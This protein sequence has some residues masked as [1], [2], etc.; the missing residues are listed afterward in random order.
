ML[1]AGSCRPQAHIW[2][3]CHV[4]FLIS[5]SLINPSR[6]HM[7][8]ACGFSMMKHLCLR[9]WYMATLTQNSTIGKAS[10]LFCNR[11][12]SGTMLDHIHQA[13]QHGAMKMTVGSCVTI[14]FH[15]AFWPCCVFRSKPVLRSTGP[16]T[17]RPSSAHA[18]LARADPANSSKKSSLPSDFIQK[19]SARLL[20]SSSSARG[21]GT[22]CQSS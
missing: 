4:T 21:T 16:P 8:L 6:F 11:F 12:S 19:A 22:S 18:E 2:R 1:D 14:C 15:A 3:S 9:V 20:D 17:R 13:R 7:A 10:C 5:A